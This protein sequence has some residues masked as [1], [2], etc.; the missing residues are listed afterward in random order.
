[1]THVCCAYHLINHSVLKLHYW[2]HNNT[3][4]ETAAWRLFGAHV[5]DESLRIPLVRC[6]RVVL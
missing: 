4:P 6:M 1:M 2:S 5:K 3:E